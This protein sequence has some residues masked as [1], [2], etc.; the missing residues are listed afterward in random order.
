M[1]R[2]SPVISR[3]KQQ[4]LQA[5][6]PASDARGPV[7]RL[8]VWPRFH[9]YRILQDLRTHW[10]TWSAA[11]QGIIL[12]TKFKKRNYSALLARRKGKA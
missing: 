1:T 7:A 4:L 2:F 9:H 11:G 12:A 5:N 3:T 6:I 10:R 8:L